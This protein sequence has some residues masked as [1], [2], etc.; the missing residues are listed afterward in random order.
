MTLGLIG[1]GK[2]GRALARKWLL[3][4]QSSRAVT[5]L[6]GYDPVDAAR[7]DAAKDGVRVI[8]SL[9][10]LLDQ[11]TSPK[12]L[13]VMVPSA[14]T[15]AVLSNIVGA[16]APG[17][18]VVDGGNTR[19]DQTERVAEEFRKRG[20]AFV[21]VGVSG[22]PN[23]GTVGFSLMAGGETADVERVRPLLAELAAP[24]GAYGHVGPNGAGH[25]VKMVHNG[26]EYGMMES[27]AEGVDLLAHA[28][29][30]LSLQE[31]GRVWRGGSVIR[32]YLVDLLADILATER[33]EVVRGRVGA[34]GE[35]N[36]TVETAR[37][38]GVALPAIEAAV[39]RRR[40]SQERDI[41]AAKILAL[42]REKFGGHR[43][44]RT[45][46]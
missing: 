7:A 2:M 36:W 19:Y 34:T 43:A 16:L 1:L 35:G 32:S 25:F 41:F 33:L 17:D 23:G 30:A 14:A 44:E 6:L 12:T 39:E 8:G 37:E 46:R 4:T 38:R 21:D 11:I 45:G 10:E 5:T 22:G 20:I 31:V 24:A 26:I 28:P 13:W 9:K 15:D 42:L 27:L 18:L 29:Y 40:E 3:G